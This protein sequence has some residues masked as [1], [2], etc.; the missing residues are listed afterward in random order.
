MEILEELGFTHTMHNWALAERMLAGQVGMKNGRV[1]IDL[2]WHLHYSGEDRRP[3]ALD[4]DAMLER[5]RQAD[6]SGLKA[7]ILDPVDQLLTLAFHAARSD[8]HCL[9]WVKDIERSLAVEEPDLD[10]LVR[11]CRDERCG[12]PVGVMLGR[13]S[14]LLDADVPPETIASA[15]AA[16]AAGSR[17]CGLRRRPSDSAERATDPHA[18]LHALGALVTRCHRRRGA[19]PR[20]P[21]PG[22]AVAPASRARDRQ[23]R[24]E[25]Q[26]PPR[27]HSPARALSQLGAVNDNGA[28]RGTLRTIRLA[29]S[30]VYRSGRRQ[31]LI[32][33]GASVITSAAIAGQ[34][35]AGRTILDLLAENHRVDA[36]ELAPYLALLGVLLMVSAMSQAFASELRLPLSEQVARHTM[37]EVLD[38]AT[39]VELDAYEG[40]EF[41]DR[42]QRARL[43]AGAQSSAVVFGLVTII[44]TLVVTVGVLVVLITVAPVLVPIALLGYLPITLVNVRNNRA[45]YQLEVEQTE[46]L[47]NRSYL[48][49]VMTDR[50]E[51]K[52]IR[53]YDVAPDAPPLAR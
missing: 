37:D 39:E 53:A 2:H 23:P 9:V 5:R 41:H 45:R 51:A 48:E 44:S 4:P 47:R 31:L 46:L 6:V 34:L 49:Y 1:T 33:V 12:P 28:V 13:S 50:T 42:L 11:R 18:R 38:V 21:G 24:R 8:G 26:L 35:L 3:F 30:L 16:S 10:E 22:A 20:R 25:G 7:W 29:V 36:G 14:T 32:I 19:G 27:C 40:S 15:D 52:E 17:P 43:A